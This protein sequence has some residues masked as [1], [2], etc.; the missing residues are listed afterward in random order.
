M[1]VSAFVSQALCGLQAT[2]LSLAVIQMSVGPALASAAQAS[3]DLP[4]PGSLGNAQSPIKHVIVIIGENR[5]FDHVFATYQPT[6]IKGRPQEVLNLLSEGIVSLQGTNAV[7]GPN[8]RR[9]VQK[10]VASQESVFTLNPPSTDYTNLPNPLAGGPS[11]QYANLTGLC[12][13]AQQCIGLAEE[14]E[15]GLPDASYY[16]SLASGGTGLT[17]LVVP[18]GHHLPVIGG[19]VMPAGQSRDYQ[20]AGVVYENVLPR[21]RE[22]L[23]TVSAWRQHT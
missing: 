3:N 11:G 18:P 23:E 2:A 8:W 22:F 6:A 19:I 12:T 10:Q 1:R 14:V 5:S 13:S 20:R 17:A 7:P 15:T 16:A 4:S 21:R 9:A